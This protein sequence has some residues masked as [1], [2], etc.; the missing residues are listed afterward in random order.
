MQTSPSDG[1]SR[2][3]EGGERSQK[4]ESASLRFVSTHKSVGFTSGDLA[5]FDGS[6]EPVVREL[7]QN[8]LDAAHQAERPAEVR[9]EICEVPKDSLPGRRDY[10]R[11]FELALQERRRWHEG[12]QS[13]DEKMVCQRIEQARGPSMTPV[14]VCVDNGYGLNKRRMMALLTTGNTSKGDRGAGSFGLGHHAAFGA[15]DLRYVL[16]AAN[17][18]DNHDG[19][20]GELS[21]IA[22]GHAILATHRR[23]SDGALRAAD[24]YWIRDES[25]ENTFSESSDPFPASVPGLLL[26]YL[27]SLSDTGTVVG[28]AGFN[29]F[30]REEGE[31]CAVEMIARVAAANFSDAI[32]SRHLQV[33]VTDTRGDAQNLMNISVATHDDVEEILREIKDQRRAGTGKGGYIVGSIAYDAALTL[34]D[35][36]S[37]PS[38]R[39]MTIKCRTLAEHDRPLTQVHVF[40]RGMWIESRARGLTKADFDKQDPFSAVLSLDSGSLEEVVRAAEGPEHRGID[41]K[42]LSSGQ[43][44]ALREGLRDVAQRLRDHL[45]ERSDLQEYTPPGFAVLEG[46]LNRTAEKVRRPRSPGGGGTRKGGV[47]RGN[48]PTNGNKPKPRRKGTPSPGT[49]PRYRSSVGAV[50]GEQVITAQ[51]S[52]D[53]EVVEDAQTGVRLFAASGADASCEAPLPDSWLRILSVEDGLRRYSSS[54]PNGDLEVQIPAAAGHRRLV[55]TIAE[56]VRDP[57][58][59]E[60]DLVRRRP[61]QPNASDEASGAHANG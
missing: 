21:S 51:I 15:S 44:K 33:R 41:T 6:A 54:D 49:T 43:R 53:E 5:Q 22:S 28:I 19:A 37:I 46:Q 34:R 7:L 61:P 35:G 60:L 20:S 11:A 45:G 29:D 9:F 3:A 40:R 42:R 4:D 36:E 58:Q 50:G 16:Y 10:N 25:G 57:R 39:G 48:E 59:L 13:P 38:P 8:S 56:P 14:L 1:R 52:Y 23:E 55:V 27:D 12:N 30:N 18:R 2:G 17:Y 32:C 47:W 31:P 26:P 24:G